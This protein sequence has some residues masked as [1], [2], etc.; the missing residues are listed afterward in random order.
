MST[1]HIDRLLDTVIRQEAS[2]LHLTVGKPPSVRMSGRL[3]ELKTRAL[4]P[5]DT[6][7]LMKAITPERS[8]NEL[9]EEGGSDFGFAYGDQ[10]DE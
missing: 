1:F 2:D 7:S 9:Q 6:T 10:S 4:E 8:Q 3:I 5:A